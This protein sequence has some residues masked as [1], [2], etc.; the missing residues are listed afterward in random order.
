MLHVK[1]HDL[2]LPDRLVPNAERRLV[3][4]DPARQLADVTLA[5]VARDAHGGVG[6]L[7]AGPAER[8]AQQLRR[9][10]LLVHED[11]PRG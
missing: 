3:V 7:P 8:L 1:K 4:P 11:N 5:D 6:E 9:E 2:G 10:R